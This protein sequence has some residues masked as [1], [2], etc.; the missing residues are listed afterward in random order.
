MS[1]VREVA[2]PLVERICTEIGPR[3]AGSA[4]ERQ[5]QEIFA[6]VFERDGLDVGWH[7]FKYNQ[8][9]YANLVLHFGLAVVG[10]ALSGVMPLVGA[11]LHGLV[12]VSYALDTTKR[13]M[14]LR[15]L[16][17]FVD[18]QNLLATRRAKGAVRRRLVVMGHADSAYTGWL[19]HEK[20]LR[21][22][23]QSPGPLKKSMV[24]ILVTLSVLALLEVISLFVAVPF[25]WV[26]AWLLTVPS[27]IGLVLNIQVVA[28]NT[29]VP[30]AADNLSGCAALVVLHR[31]WAADLPDDVEVVYVVTGAEEVSTGGAW[32]LARDMRTVWDPSNTT[33]LAIDTLAGGDIR[34]LVNG[35]LWT[36]TI[37]AGLE[38]AAMETAAAHPEFG[39]VSR[40]AIPSGAT[41]A[42]PFE[43]YG[44]EAISVGCVDP[45]IGAPRNYHVPADN[46]QNLDLDQFERTVGFIE[47]LGR[48]LM[49]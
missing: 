49:R 13:A 42:A 19:F 22:A 16:F 45:D 14:V 44:F 32:M 29:L 11:F 43:R 31:R 9:L 36:G 6:Q 1:D 10:T 5:A 38:A 39:A 15:R 12:V 47:Q 33:V 8:S 40:Y 18:S 35:E 7:R 24:V 27:V 23:T 48:R 41:D 37:P 2:F 34:L 26:W 46:P 21:N 3:L 30:G 4:Q 25:F 28:H 20:M 17:P